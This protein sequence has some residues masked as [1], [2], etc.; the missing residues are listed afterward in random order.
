MSLRAQTF[1][2]VPGRISGTISDS[3]SVNFLDINNDGWEDIYISN[4]LQGGQRDLLY[5]NRGDGTF[6]EEEDM[7]IVRAVNPSDGASF[8]DFNN[9]GHIDGVISSW[10]GAEDLLYLNDANGR[11]KY[12]PESGIVPGSYAETA[13]FGDYDQDGW[14]DL[15]ITNSGGSKANY[16]Y[17]N[18]QDGT[19]ERITD[20]ILVAD[21]RLSRGAVWTDINNDGRPDLFVANEDNAPNDIYLA[22]GNG[23]YEKFTRGSIV[24]HGMSSM[25]ASWGDIDNDGDLD[26]FVGNSGFFSGQRNQLY[27][28]FGDSFGEILDD[29]VAKFEGCTFGSAFGDYDN[30]GDLDL[31]ISNGF[32]NGNMQNALFENQGDGRFIDVS[33]LLS[34]NLNVCSYGLAWG[35]IDNDGFLDLLTANCKNGETDTEKSN[36]LLRNLGNDHHWIKVK[37]IGSRSNAGAVGAKV[38]IKTMIE[39]NPVWQVREVSTQ[40]GYA[41]QN[42]M[43]L[44]FGLKEA[45]L[46]DSLVVEWPAGGRDILTEVAADQQLELVESGMPTGLQPVSLSE[47]V[48]QISPNPIAAPVDSLLLDIRNERS[49]VNGTVRLLDMQGKEIRQ[50]AVRLEHGDQHLNLKLDHYELSPGVYQLQL[51]VDR[52]MLSRKIIVQ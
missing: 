45:N 37:L 24:V 22:T 10:Y 29:P 40:S 16:L 39:G 27:R 17:R 33:N 44:H 5:I 21:L 51:I 30:D 50:Q 42:S 47:V 7:E 15:Y 11:L 3:R 48:V 35:D 36:L 41:G 23:N 14:L 28:N 26:L 43:V 2:K 13:V 12:K 32:C 6:T 19:F 52:K 1:E 8:A 4:G 20:H 49:T 31:A 46:I 25:T 34:V 38:R 9:D 18:R